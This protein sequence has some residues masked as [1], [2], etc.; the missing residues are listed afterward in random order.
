[1]KKQYSSFSGTLRKR[2]SQAGILKTSSLILAALFLLNSCSAKAQD[3]SP[4][5]AEKIFADAGIP[6]LKKSVSIRDFSLP[7]VSS[8]EENQSLS[9]LKGKLVFL[10]FW[11]TWCGPCRAEMPS[12]EALYARYKDRGFEILAVNCQESRT[13]VSSFMESNNL[14]LP[15]VLDS[16][17]KVSGAYGVQAIPSSFIINREGK[18]IIRLVGSIDWDTPKIHAAMEKL[19]EE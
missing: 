17:G 13:D 18:I 9:G 4:G 8:I 1:M 5:S 6:L 3:S 11:A 16:D 10:N 15:V 7:L 2:I 12:M 19:L 14:S